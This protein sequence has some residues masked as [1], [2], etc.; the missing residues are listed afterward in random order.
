MLMVACSLVM[1]C[2]DGWFCRDHDELQS[3]TLQHLY[4][5]NISRFDPDAEINAKEKRVIA[6]REWA[7]TLDD[8]CI[9]AVYM[10]WLDYFD[11]EIAGARSYKEKQINAQNR[12]R[13][14]P[15]PPQ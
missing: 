13:Q 10:D 5:L 7:R 3:A 9:R 2:A 6:L 1:G 8:R 15:A 14:I 12:A 4:T 11:R